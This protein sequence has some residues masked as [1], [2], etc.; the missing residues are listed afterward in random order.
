MINPIAIAIPFF[1]LLIGLELLVARWQKQRFFRFAD[2]IADLGCGVSDQASAIFLGAI[3]VGIWAL[4]RE[5]LRVFELAPTLGTWVLAVLLVDLGYYWWHRL[6]HR[7][8]FMWAGHVV[9]HQSDE[10][11][12]TVALRQD[13]LGSIT[14]W[15]FYLPLAVLGVPLEV[16][17]GARAI[18]LLYQFWIHTRVVDKLGPIETI[19][20]TPSHHRVHHGVNRAYIDKNYAGIFIVF[21]RLF[22]TFEPEREPVVYGTVTPFRSWNPL[23]AQVA[24]WVHIGR[25]IAAAPR[26]SDKLK[27]PFM[28]PEWAPQGLPPHVFPSD[29]DQAA[30]P[31]YEADAPAFHAYIAVQFVPV[32]AV[33]TVMLAL[34]AI[35]PTTALAGAAAWVLTSLLAFGALLEGRAWAIPLELVRLVAGAVAAGLALW[36]SPLVALPASFAVLSAAWLLRQGQRPAPAVA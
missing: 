31:R 11:N 19:M 3:G 21:D 25:L 22:G 6:S 26:W 4:V 5:H 12:L 15:P 8:N 35:A 7:I 27:A 33:L 34:E 30:R 24:Y 1:F 10:Y 9:H 2:S 29:A 17:L 14:S 23:W 13:V 20:N 18:D 16:Y 36:S 32:A 28:P